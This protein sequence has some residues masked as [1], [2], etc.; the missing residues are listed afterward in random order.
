MNENVKILVCAHKQDFV[1]R[2]DVYTPIHVG[3]AL[4]DLDL[5]FPGDDTGDNISEKNPS[6][7]E[8]TAMYWAWKNLKGVDIIGFSHYR[9]YFNFSSRFHFKNDPSIPTTVEKLERHMEKNKVDF[10]AL[11]GKSDIIVWKPIRLSVTLYMSYCYAHMSEDMRTVMKIIDEIEPEYSRAF[12]KVI[13]RNK[14]IHLANMFVCR[15]EVFDDYC[16][17]LFGILAEAEKRINVEHYSP[18]QKRVF[19]FLAERLLNV[20]I[21]KNKLKKKTFPVFFIK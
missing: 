12:H 4:S 11:L 17:W 3:K 8:L 6:Y 14:K 10:N 19:G 18:Y 16:R 2:D 21:Y 15:W 5:G 9:R 13:R 20:Y 1:Y 7:C